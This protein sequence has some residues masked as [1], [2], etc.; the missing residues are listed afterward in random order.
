LRSPFPA[1][2]ELQR[3]GAAASLLLL[4][5]IPPAGGAG[6]VVAPT[7]KTSPPDQPEVGGEGNAD[8]PVWQITTDV[9]DDTVTVTIHDGGED[10]LDDGRRLYAAETLELTASAADPARASMRADV[11]Y[12]WQEHAFQ[13]EIR[14]RST[15]TSDASSFDLEVELEV[16]VDGEP[17]FRRDWRESI[18]RRLV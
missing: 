4:P 16:D 6:D 11:V 3:G 7:F 15:Q 8:R 9:I 12:R 1:T 2:F 10:I 13:T 5:V 14:A 17:F 18:E